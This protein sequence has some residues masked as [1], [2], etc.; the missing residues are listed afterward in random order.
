MAECRDLRS[1][2]SMQLAPAMKNAQ[3][4]SEG[5]VDGQEVKTSRLDN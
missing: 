4:S 2:F 5:L 1:G 3:T